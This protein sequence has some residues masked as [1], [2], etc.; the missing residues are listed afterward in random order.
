MWTRRCIQALRLEPQP[1]HRAPVTEVFLDDLIEV[2]GLH[3]SVPDLFRVD[4]N[5]LSV[6]ALIEAAGLV[7]PQR[8]G[9]LRRSEFIF[10]QRMKPALS[11]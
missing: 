10:E 1:L 5:R 7:Y 4:N 3:E 8:A 6:L 2:L 9:N 11:I